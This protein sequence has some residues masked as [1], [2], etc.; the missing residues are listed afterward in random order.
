[1]AE[2]FPPSWRDLIPADEARMGAVVGTGYDPALMAKFAKVRPDERNQRMVVYPTSCAPGRP[3]PTVIRIGEDF[4]GVLMP[5]RG[6]DGD[7]HYQRPAWLDEPNTD[8]DV[9]GK[10]R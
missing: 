2:Q 6:P 1:M 7:E 10:V 5:L 9:A 4:I 3:G 8:D